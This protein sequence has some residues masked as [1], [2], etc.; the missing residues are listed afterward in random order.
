MCFLTCAHGAPLVFPDF[1]VPAASE[2]LQGQALA[3]QDQA[4]AGAESY[5]LLARLQN[6]LGR[7]DDAKR[8]GRQALMCDPNRADINSFLGKVFLEEGR[9]ED[10]VSCFHKALEIDPKSAGDYRRL[11]MVLEQMGDHEGARKTLS[12]AVDLTPTDAAAQLMLGRVLVDERQFSDAINHLRTACRLDETSENAFY[13]LSQAQAKIG[14]KIAAAATLKT[15]L[16]LRE[17]A[18]ASLAAQ[19]ADYDNEKEMRRIAAGFHTDAAAFFFQ[20]GRQ[21]LA[22]AHL[23]QAARVNPDEVKSH[24]TLAAFYLKTGALGS[25]KEEYENLTRLRPKQAVYRVRLGLVLVR[26][27][28]E[29]GAAEELK[30]ALELDPNQL[31]ALDNLARLCLGA[32]RDLPEAVILC[33][34]SVTLQPTAANYD[35]LAQACYL[36]GQNGDARAASDQAARLEPGNAVYRE[37]RQRFGETR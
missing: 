30:Q 11:G 15:F 10:A 6:R 14:D 4:G 32:R 2:Y 22:E 29:A 35:L 37:H 16:R 18:K 27:K 31:D 21:D 5:F 1:T 12:T 28:D 7:P 24:E 34:R 8:L 26:L 33:R 3:F 13:V 9:F 19:D 20:H 36:N 25:A 17:R 23:K